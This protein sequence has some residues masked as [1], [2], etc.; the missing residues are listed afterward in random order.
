MHKKS[1]SFFNYKTLYGSLCVLSL[2]SPLVI[3]AK[4][5][6]QLDESVSYTMNFRNINIIEY[7]RFVAKISKINFIF[8]E[9]EL[10]FPVTLVSDQPVS[11]KNLFSALAQVLEVNGFTLSDQS[12]SILISK[13]QGSSQLGALSP[14]IASVMTRIY[15]IENINLATLT[16]IIK[17][18]ISK[19]ALVESLP[20]TH[21]LIITDTVPSLDKLEQLIKDLDG[22]GSNLKI[23]TYKI[24][25]QSAQ[26]LA[27]TLKQ[28]MAPFQG[29]N[30]YLTI[31]QTSNNQLLVIS[32][33]YL[34]QQTSQ[35]LTALDIPDAPLPI[36]SG[37]GSVYLYTPKFRSNT[38]L[39]S[40]LQSI[41]VTL[42]T[43]GP[44]AANLVAM[45]ENVKMPLG[46][47]GLIFV[48]TKN[49]W[50]KLQELLASIDNAQNK[51]SLYVYQLQSKSYLAV[52]ALL[53][54]TASKIEET[55]DPDG[56]VPAIDSMEYNQQSNSLVFLAS[57]GAIAK[58]KE[59]L[60]NL[61]KEVLDENSHSSFFIYELKNVP[62]DQILQELY[63]L[64]PT[65]TSGDFKATI[66][67]IKQIKWLKTTNSLLLT[68]SA[69]TLTNVEA[70][71]DKLDVITSASAIAG[72]S[73]FVVYPLKSDHGPIIE[74]QLHNMAKE[75]KSSSTQSIAN[76]EALEKVKYIP[77]SNSMMIF[78][79]PETIL[80]VETLVTRLDEGI[81]ISPKT[82]F[83]IYNLK[84]ASGDAVIS[85]LHEMALHIADA[86]SQSQA[87]KECLE[88]TKFISATNSIMISGS[89]EAI[90][91]T[92]GI[93]EKMDSTQASHSQLS[94]YLY[95][96][97][98][99]SGN[100]LIAQLQNFAN[101][102]PSNTLADKNVIESIN[103]LEWI[104]EDNALLISGSQA[105][106]DRVSS[107]IAQ[108]D[109]HDKPKN[110]K[111]EFLIY[112]P[113][114][115]PLDTLEH[116][117]Q[118]YTVALKESGFNDT[119][120]IETI[121]TAQAVPSA[122]HLIFT[123]STESISKVKSILALIDQSDPQTGIEHVGKTTF[124]IHQLRALTP[125]QFKS[126][127]Q[128]F[129]AGL[130]KTN[131][132]DRQIAECINHMQYLKET[133]SFLFNG[134]S[135]ILEKVADIANK[136]DAFS[137]QTS[138]M[139]YE[140][141]NPHYVSGLDLIAQMC[142]FAQGLNDS[143][144]KD[145]TLYDSIN[146][147][148]WIEKSNAMIITGTP[149]SLTKVSDLLKKFDVPGNSKGE[150]LKGGSGFMVFKLQYHLGTEIQQAL[151]KLAPTFASGGPN[152]N[153]GLA[154]AINS[155]QWIQVTNSLVASGD[156]E[157]LEKLKTLIS[158][159]D[160]PLKQVFI[161]V[162]VI[163]TD[164]TNAQNFGLQWFGKG[165][166]K[167]QVN[168]GTGNFAGSNPQ[169]FQTA[170]VFQNNINS[171]TTTNPPTA[172]SIPLMATPNPGFDLGVI[173]DVL[174]HKGKSFLSLGSL[175][176]AVQQDADS[177]VVMNPKILAQ[178]NQNSTIF[179]GQ[180]IP[181]T[182]SNVTN[183]QQG[184]TIQTSN[185]EYRNVGVNLSITPKLGDDNIV[186]LEI[187]YTMSSVVANTNNGG[188]SSG[189]LQGIQTAQ[190]NLT[191]CV[192]VPDQH[193]V[194]LSGMLNDNKT[195]YKTGIPCLG[196][197]PVIGLAFSDNERSDVKVN[198]LIFIRPSIIHDMEDLTTLTENQEDKYRNM[199]NRQVIKEEFDE[200]LNLVKEPAGE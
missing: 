33:P 194:V 103:Q 105:T 81:H 187:T 97:Q 54:E 163:Q 63:Q 130:S 57:A 13:N 68:G 136:V 157:N 47:T 14:T 96:L 146:N 182:G 8:N 93:I 121:N 92:Q 116:S 127:M 166:L 150:N 28:V 37:S 119:N 58:L 193:F 151:N 143:G 22:S 59:I 88:S 106:I 74:K 42:K 66:K 56:L 104:K 156:A 25:F 191:T 158:E 21:Q 78:G 138:T 174:F 107:L 137:S 17:T 7:I 188:G 192:H 84:D 71:I 43:E 46:S 135:K 169:G 195:H 61:D 181:F 9:Q 185:L 152:A 36:E 178:D 128:S 200:G 15:K 6:P 91:F 41:A 30:P 171:I 70:L 167:N 44:S 73:S 86:S 162:L 48:G 50:D 29:S 164:T 27:E 118:E 190:T 173:G 79:N 100:K 76:K 134:S 179:I 60:P 175:V 77:E 189:G 102:L 16:Q 114:F 197:L 131:L 65:L 98:A 55:G 183:T 87:I 161:E 177:T 155:I 24:Q 126:S 141:Y 26:I 168:F 113:Q 19:G 109:T 90:N 144:I 11:A 123:G 159:V 148:K 35:T 120:L 12:G 172:S 31:P 40:A 34:I 3:D 145:Q 101:K 49:T 184:G 10:S 80:F 112:S 82:T 53:H 111:G 133:N 32:T 115:L 199:L 196:G 139:T 132:Q 5:S 140:I 180:N 2:I 147:I 23:L 4:V 154:A 149:E 170:P 125:D 45:I 108:Y 51:Q 75:V 117:L 124:F 38:D 95:K 62:G 83:I 160:V 1:L 165:Q 129:E 176:N 142:Q 39:V 186:T 72:R 52:E 69:K 64:E 153:P 122:N 99:L 94:F 20:E 89:Q 198:T 18:I 110:N 67:C 85:Q